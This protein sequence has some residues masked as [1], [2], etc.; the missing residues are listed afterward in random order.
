MNDIRHLNRWLNECFML[1][2]AI[3]FIRR[4]KKNVVNVK[5]LR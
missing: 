2:D 3:I 1:H 5:R 4:I